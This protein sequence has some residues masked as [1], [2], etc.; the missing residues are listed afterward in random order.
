M[1]NSSITNA[2]S[3]IEAA[4][5]SSNLSVWKPYAQALRAMTRVKAEAAL[6]AMGSD[7]NQ[8]RRDFACEVMLDSTSSVEIALSEHCEVQ[9]LMVEAGHP[10]PS[11]LTLATFVL[12]YGEQE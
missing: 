6:E 4:P 8:V 10:M 1:W 3:Q 9:R 2:A 7:W 11:D 5:S 12:E